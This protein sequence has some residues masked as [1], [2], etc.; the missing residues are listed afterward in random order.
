MV[1]M[2]IKNFFFFQTLHYTD[3]SKNHHTSISTLL[4]YI[5]ADVTLWSF[6]LA[7]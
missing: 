6:D 1:H 5:F 7:T 4:L 3:K 2:L